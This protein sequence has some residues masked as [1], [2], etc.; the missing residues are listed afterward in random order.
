ME[1]TSITPDDL[2][3]SK[4][5]RQPKCKF[6]THYSVEKDFLGK[7]MGTTITSPDLNAS[8]C[9]DFTWVHLN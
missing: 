3:C 9:D 5:E 4:F 6:C 7:C 2:S 1:K 8:K